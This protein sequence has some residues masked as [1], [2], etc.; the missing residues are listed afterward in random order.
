M[1]VSTT[2]HRVS[3]TSM[4]LVNEGGETGRQAF[5][6][7]YGDGFPGSS[8]LMVLKKKIT[9]SKNDYLPTH[10]TTEN[11]CCR[12]RY[13]DHF[14]PIPHIFLS[15]ALSRFKSFGNSL[16]YQSS[17]A[18]LTILCEQ[19][20]K[21]AM[22]H[23]TLLQLCNTCLLL[24]G[25]SDDIRLNVSLLIS[26]GGRCAHAPTAA[27]TSWCVI[28]CDRLPHIHVCA[29]TSGSAHTRTKAAHQSISNH[30]L[31]FQTD[32]IYKQH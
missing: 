13:K 18:L 14:E 27:S 17:N 19:R 5:A 20:L 12:Y 24:E 7:S 22:H 11:E 30:G 3:M 10:A 15:Q 23:L 16:K 28:D 6:K 29:R 31:I 2:C 26:E 9:L 32:F 8:T 1:N 21:S 25:V 4:C